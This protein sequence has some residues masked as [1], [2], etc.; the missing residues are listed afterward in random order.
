MDIS[1]EGKRALV[2]GANSGIGA[3]IARALAS[4]GARVAVNH[5]V[6]PE[7]AAAVVAD[8]RRQ[9][10]EASA[11]EA[12][13]SDARQV[14]AMFEALD[15]RWDGIDV[16]VNN[17]GVDGARAVAW[18]ADPAEWF[19]VIRVDLLGPFQCAREALRR[20]V[21]RKSGV[22]LNLTSVHEKIAWGG[23]SAYTAAKAGLSM[24]TKTLAQEAAPFG[25]RVVALAPGAIRTPI[26]RAVWSDP[27]GLADLVAKIP[28]GR[29]GEPEEVA[30]V[31]AFL[32]SDAA[33][34]LTGSTVYVDGA[35]TDYP[36]FAR[37]G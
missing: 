32:V 25:V 8:I 10:G 29:M 13:V 27:A 24:L 37:G 35:M 23:Y 33:S 12:D 19:R 20:M 1:L 21:A 34:Y 22:I 15:R 7:A 17:A 28:L 2:T 31:A 36:E 26:N 9:G 3:S 11:F 18:E 14:A 4:A 5:V 6:D 30:R 16:L